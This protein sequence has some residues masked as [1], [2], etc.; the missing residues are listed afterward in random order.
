MGRCTWDRTLFDRIPGN[1]EKTIYVD[2]ALNVLTVPNLAPEFTHDIAESEPSQ[3]SRLGVDTECRLHSFGV[4]SRW[5]ARLAMVR[6]RSLRFGPG[7][8][9][10]QVAIKLQPTGCSKHKSRLHPRSQVL[11]LRPAVHMTYSRGLASACDRKSLVYGPHPTEEENVYIR[12][13]GVCL[14]AQKA[15]ASR[16]LSWLH[17][18]PANS[19]FT[20]T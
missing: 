19:H 4:S 6:F 11:G 18:W 7:L 17:L 9:C 3:A 13:H 2:R 1:I 15:V 12:A 5:L 8:S 20:K 14:L 10:N 16:C